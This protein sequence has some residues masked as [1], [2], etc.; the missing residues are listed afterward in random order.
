[1]EWWEGW[2]V[3]AITINTCINT[4]V[5]FRGRKILNRA[6]VSNENNSD[7]IHTKGD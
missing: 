3:L 4:I 7:K 6:G 2:L 5:F 1:M